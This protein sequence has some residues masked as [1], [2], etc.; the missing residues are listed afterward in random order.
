MKILF[1]TD[2]Y[3]PKPLAN[4]ICVEK[5]VNEMSKSNE[6]FILAY[7]GL[8]EKKEYIY[9][10][11]KIIKIKPR[12]FFKLREYGENN[13]STM[14][15]KIVL[16]IAHIIQ[17]IKKI[18][19]IYKFPLTSP[20]FVNKMYRFAKK[21]CEKEKIDIVISAYNPLEACIVGSKL[22]KNKIIKYH[23]IYM[24]DTLTN[25]YNK[26]NIIEKFFSY[27]GLKWEKYFIKNSDLML[28]MKCYKEYYNKTIYNKCRNKIKFVDIPY[29]EKIRKNNF[30][31]LEKSSSS[32]Y[33]YAGALIKNMRNPEYTCKVFKE[34]LKEKKENLI[35]YSRGDCEEIL[36]KYQ[37]LSN[38]KII[39]KNYIKKDEMDKLV[40]A[41]KAIITIG[42]DNSQMISSKIFE[43]IALNKKIIHFY[44]NKNDSNIPYLKKYENCLCLY[45]KDDINN[46]IY[47]IDEFLKKDIKKYTYTE[48]A[49]I[50]KQNTPQFTANI[51]LSNYKKNNNI[52]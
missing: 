47:K 3:Y 51:I 49:K 42:N 17:K 39:S 21:I 18:L 33:I 38:N 1:L 31:L 10:N 22:K 29:I 45:D 8:N 48:L 40:I 52:L 19:F 46:N 11:T 16:K 6:V 7:K 34:Y 2:F 35:F 27:S 12:L 4:G 23:V 9:N 15:G 5:I 24:I 13:K 20:L 26:K 44:S 36:K 43:Y 30:E 28:C 32:N 37:L 25:K 14:K 50:Y 41:A